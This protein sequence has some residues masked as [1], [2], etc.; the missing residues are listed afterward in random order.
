[1]SRHGRHEYVLK[2]FC[3]HVAMVS[4]SVQQRLPNDAIHRICQPVSL[5]AMSYQTSSVLANGWQ[6]SR[7]LLK[8]RRQDGAQSRGKVETKEAVHVGIAQT[9]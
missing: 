3:K 6:Q 8:S 4:N 1:M 9:I 5:D 7:W 2:G